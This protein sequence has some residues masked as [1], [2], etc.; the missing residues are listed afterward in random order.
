VPARGLLGPEVAVALEGQQ[1]VEEAAKPLLVEG[2]QRMSSCQGA[3]LA[4][5]CWAAVLQQ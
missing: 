2:W 5:W 3:S 1:K 4:V